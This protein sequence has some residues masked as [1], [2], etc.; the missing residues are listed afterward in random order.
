LRLS[1]SVL[2]KGS[3]LP[4]VTRSKAANDFFV[5]GGTLSPDSQSYIERNSDAVLL[6]ALSR[7]RY[8]YVLNSRQ[9]GKSSLSVRTIAKLQA[10]G[11]RTAFV[12]LTQIGGRNVTPEQ[13]YMGLCSEL[14]RSLGVRSELLAYCKQ[15]ADV[16]PMQRFFGSLRDVVLEKIEAPLVIFIDEIDATKNLSFNTDE[17]FAGIRE[18]F[19]RRVREPEFERLTF[20]LLGVAVPSDLISNP[21]TTPFNIGERIPL[22]DF[23]LQELQRFGPVL[24]AN[25]S[26]L[27]ERIHHWTNGQPFLTQ[28][29]CQTVATQD[30]QTAADVDTVV[31]E[32]FLGPKARDTNINLADVANRALNGG[33]TEADPEKFRADL[34][35]MYE[36]AW[37]GGYVKDDEANR[38]AVVLKLSGLLRTEGSR[39]R[40]RNRIYQRVFDQD[41]LRDSMPDQELRRQEHSYRR[42]LLRGTAAAAAIIATVSILGLIAW[43]ARQEAVQAQHKLDYELYV[44]DMSGMRFFEETGDIARM[45]QVLERTADSPHRGFEWAFW[46]GRLP[47]PTR[48]T[49]WATPRR[50]SGRTAFCRG[51]ERT[52]ASRTP[53]WRQPRWS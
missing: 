17:F 8:C 33:A 18:C 39:L 26:K 31:L 24:G 36:R 43:R 19:N 22:Q 29:L 48:S 51:T 27:I 25:G 5:S 16:S 23:S 12:D 32:Q 52:S 21:A 50:A 41:W 42:G 4:N 13:W 30:L 6:D 15:H 28:S 44:A 2:Y 35:S 45:E 47:T 53:C 9:M 1:R 37:K 11:T 14:G 40:V 10:M 20:C 7:R 46:N 38:V 34:L 49:P 3:D